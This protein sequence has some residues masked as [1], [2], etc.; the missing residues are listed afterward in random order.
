MIFVL[1]VN[2]YGNTQ[3]KINLGEVSTNNRLLTLLF[4]FFK[5]SIAREFLQKS[6]DLRIILN[7]VLFYFQ[8]GSTDC[9]SWKNDYPIPNRTNY[10]LLYNRNM[11]PK[12]ARQ[13]ILETI[14]KQNKFY[15]LAENCFEKY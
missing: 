2:Y 13:A 8:M 10:P 4:K 9:M 6:N 7:D 5:L 3:L 15:Q 14:K 12:L 1:N 11:Q